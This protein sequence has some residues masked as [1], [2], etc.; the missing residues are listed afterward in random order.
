MKIL[1]L[2]PMTHQTKNVVR[3]LLYGCWCNGKRIGGATI[4]PFNHLILTGLLKKE[5]LDADFLDAQMERIPLSK[6]K[7]VI[8]KYNVVIIATSTMS[9]RE[10]AQYL[11]ALKKG[12]DRLITVVFGAHPTFMPSYC[13]RHDG[14]DIIVKHEPELILKKLMNL[15]SLNKDYYHL[16]GIGFKKNNQIIINE[17]H[18]FIDNLDDIPFPDVDLL[19]EGMD[20]FNPI[21]KRIPYITTTTS[22]GCPGKCVFCTAPYFDGEIL[23]FQSAD[24]V[25]REVE[26]FISKGIKEIYFR[27]DTFF[28]SKKRDQ[29]IF[30]HI[31]RNNLDITWLANARIASID[32]ETMRLARQ[33]GCHTI[34]L[35][36]ES[37]VQEILDGIK[38]GYK[39][40][41]AYEVFKWA[42]K[43]KIK[44]HAHVMLGN[45]GDTRESI[46]QTIKFVL[47]LNPTTASFGICTPYPGT[48]LF[49]DLK[50]KFP[51]I[52]DGSASDL[53]KLHTQG[54]FNEYYTSLSKEELSSLV[55]Y[56]YRKFYLRLSYLLKSIKW[57][58]SGVDDIKRLSIA[59][60][61]IFDYIFSGRN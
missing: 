26:Y 22:R 11:L 15:I 46:K 55:R 61:N 13:L 60:A 3:D 5:G 42:K 57:Q 28:V 40:E 45:P 24:Y 8:S 20:Y 49:E 9:F 53:S 16:K 10:D 36:I 33:A 38:K 59:A 19:P 18:P 12:N 2:N 35:G 34:K 44:T 31:I 47:K 43:L 7:S 27:D 37:G 39:I 52:E 30:E 21:V 6:I 29:A 50:G 1:I 56:A 14:I 17:K 41:K 23:R 48:P 25:I 54:L 51:E 4:P 58:I 32:K